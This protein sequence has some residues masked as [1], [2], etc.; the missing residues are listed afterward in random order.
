MLALQFCLSQK[1]QKQSRSKYSHVAPIYAANKTSSIVFV[2]GLQGHPKKTWTSKSIASKGS[3]STKIEHKTPSK[4]LKF[5]SKTRLS[6]TSTRKSTN[7]LEEHITFWPYHLLHNDCKNVRILT[8]GYNSN[9]SEFFSGSTNKGNILSY[10]R[11]LLGD[12]TGER[13]SCVRENT[14][15]SFLN[16]RN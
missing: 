9:I 13:G 5:W 12:L 1:N 14:M 6:S 15:P 2:H 10:S 8:W 4:G 7:G 11:D 16:T 3:N